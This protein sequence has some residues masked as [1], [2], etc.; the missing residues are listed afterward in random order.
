MFTLIEIEP[1][2]KKYQLVGKYETPKHMYYATD[3]NIYD[4]ERF[5]GNEHYMLTDDGRIFRLLN[6]RSGSPEDRGYSLKIETE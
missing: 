4:W 1:E 5:F 6:D 3:T 2:T